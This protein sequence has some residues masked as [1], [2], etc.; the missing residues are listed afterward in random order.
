MKFLQ[1]LTIYAAALNML[2]CGFF[3]W[4]FLLAEFNHVITLTLILIVK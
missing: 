2:F 3:F 4:F 1:K